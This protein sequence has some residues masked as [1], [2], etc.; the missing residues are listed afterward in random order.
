MQFYLVRY[1]P[2]VIANMEP[3][4]LTILIVM[5]PNIMF[6]TCKVLFK[7][8]ALANQISTPMK[9]SKFIGRFMRVEIVLEF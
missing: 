4:S 9:P 8:A 7:L 3:K 1:A 5:Y 6:W 2:T